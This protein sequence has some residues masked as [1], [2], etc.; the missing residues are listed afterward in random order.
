LAPAVQRLTRL[1]AAAAA[2]ADADAASSLNGRGRSAPS[3]TLPVT[4]SDKA[5]SSLLPIGLARRPGRP[6]SRRTS[7]LVVV[8]S[9]SVSVRTPR[10]FSASRLAAKSPTLSFVLLRPAI[11]ADTRSLDG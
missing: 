8:Y 4:Q 7:A 2:D 1:A 9:L 10:R 6:A 3:C 11:T 5:L